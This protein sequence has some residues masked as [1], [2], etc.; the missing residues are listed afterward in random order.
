MKDI[1]KAICWIYII[2]FS[3]C[4]NCYILMKLS[5]LYTAIAAVIFLYLNFCA[6]MFSPKT[7]NPHMKI[8][9]H[10]SVTLYVFMWSV[11]FSAA[12]HI[13]LAICLKGTNNDSLLYSCAVCFVCH[14]VLFWN[15]II[16]VYLC[17]YELGIKHRV[18][19]ALCGM[20]PIANLIVLRRIVDV[21]SREVAAECDREQKNKE[22]ISI[23][24]CKTKYPILLVH[25]VFFRDYKYFNY[26]G[27][28]PRELERNG[29]VIYYGN[30]GS[31]ASVE[32]SAKEL[33]ER[34]KKIVEESG[35]EK[36]NI[37]AH[38]KG[39]LDCRYAIA[40]L[41]MEKY[42]ASLTT[43]NTPHR[44][45]IFADYLL[46]NIPKDIKNKVASTY[47]KALKKL[48][49]EEPDFLSAVNDLTASVC[50]ER[51]RQMPV[52]EGIFTHSIGSVMPKSRTGK[53]PLNFSYHLVKI[54]DGR[55]DGL[56][57]EDSFSYGENYT[58][59]TPDGNEGISHAD[60]IDLD[61]HNVAGF[62]VREFYVG[63]VADLKN[64]GL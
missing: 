46:N 30:H 29:A 34:I 54:F 23:S 5:P 24:V 4:A 50:V 9:N 44:G 38:S 17:S 10:G 3:F 1:S 55:N 31:A 61:R 6:G 49:D 2:L 22:R 8:T 47:N 25:G 36:L 58:L 19:G 7:T 33:S 52:P 16:C 48:G 12:Y 45:C 39:G 64:R 43:V 18:I 60:I 26:W 20:I 59:L 21:T 13:I 35:C 56:V 40:F 11:L 41:G 15:G 57:G 53:F 51:D 42:A 27:R 62:D 63:L 28:I 32:N 37:I 14:F